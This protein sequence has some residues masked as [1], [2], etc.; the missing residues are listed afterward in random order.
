VCFPFRKIDLIFIKQRVGDVTRNLA[1]A[2]YIRRIRFDRG[3]MVPHGNITHPAETQVPF[4]WTGYCR[5]NLPTFSLKAH[6]NLKTE[7]LV[8]SRFQLEWR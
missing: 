5:L 2:F 6:H 8:K 4:G 7:L 3:V 1:D